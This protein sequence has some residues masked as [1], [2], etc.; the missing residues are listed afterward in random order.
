[1]RRC[2]GLFIVFIFCN[3]FV[4]S[5]EGV[6]T[7]I[8]EMND[9]T[10]DSVLYRNYKYDEKTEKIY[11]V[12]EMIPVFSG[13]EK[14]MNEFLSQNVKYPWEAKKEGIEGLVFIR[15]IVNE[16]G[17]LTNIH[18]RKGVHPSIDNESLRVVALM[19]KWEPGKQAGVPVKTYF[20]VPV[21]FSLQ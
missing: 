1:M 17:E 13:G 7:I 5:Q 8:I 9:G 16:Q 18:V 10:E 15:F 19:P 4:F 6:D 2:M 14:K 20:I 12:V 11:N 3:S 21:R